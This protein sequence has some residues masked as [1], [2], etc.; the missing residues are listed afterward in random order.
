VARTLF[1]AFLEIPPDGQ[2]RTVIHAHRE[3]THYVDV[4]DA[5]VLADFDTPEA[6][7]EWRR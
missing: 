4:E 7:A 1:G 5:G 6:L 3:R 2:A